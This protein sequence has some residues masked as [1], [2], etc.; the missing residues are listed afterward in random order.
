MRQIHRTIGAALA[1]IVIEAGL[2]AA[3]FAQGAQP[4]APGGPAAY[5][6]AGQEAA[7][8]AGATRSLDMPILYVT[9]IEV[10]R[11][12]M[13]PQVD[14]IRVTGLTS[15][16]GWSSPQ[17]VP[18]FYGKPA[19]DILD[20]QFIATSPEQ[21]QKAD[22]FVPVSAMFTLEGGNPYKGV[23]VR[24]SANALEVKHIP[25]SAHAIIKAV[26][27]KQCIGKTFAE[28]G[29]TPAGAAGIVRAEDLP[30]HF[31]TIE[32]THGVAGI[33]HNPNRLDLILDENHK[34]VMAFWE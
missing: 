4:P 34:I 1:A 23:R 13:N 17:L 22:G 28:K 21:S 12:T 11:T 33:V 30:R 10:L 25:G 9:G 15:S 7:G 14:L 24:A 16:Q 5:M 31:R 20:L 19:D 3:A 27:C 26:D 2:V 29:K 8:P 32:P 6:G 18:F